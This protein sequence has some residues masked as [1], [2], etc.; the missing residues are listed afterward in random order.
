MIDDKIQKAGQKLA[1]LERNYA[2]ER[3]KARKTETRTKIQFG[4]LVVKAGMDKY[5]KNVIL[6]ALIDAVEN[7]DRDSAYQQLCEYKGEAAFNSFGE[8]E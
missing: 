2:L 4:G 6:G 3:M 8:E 7:L 1:R 5:P